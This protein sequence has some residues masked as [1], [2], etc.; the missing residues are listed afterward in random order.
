VINT[1]TV[2]DTELLSAGRDLKWVA[3]LGSGLD[4]IDLVQAEQ[5]GIHVIS[6][7]K[8]NA[9]AVAEHV[10]GMLLGLLRH[11]VIS[12]REVRR[13]E[14][15]R[16]KNRGRELQGMT[17]GI[18][19]FGNTG[20]AFAGKLAGWQLQVLAYDK[21]KSDYANDYPHV[22]ET[23]LEEVLT[24][25][26]VLSLHVPLTAETGYMVNG[27][28]LAKCKPGAILVNSSRG[29]I[30]D[31]AALVLALRTGHLA[32]ACLDVQENERP[33]T[34]TPDERTLYDILFA[35]SNVVLTP[36]VAGWTFAS[37]RRIAEAILRAL[38]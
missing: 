21:Y 27:A 13:G 10:V 24:H 20:S 22:R 35:M 5:R 29:K 37:K 14:W 28:F 9:N 8:A 19:G 16:E 26:D 31:T 33:D 30:V 1:R 3:R 7:P 18:I 2:A 36:H 23:T 4:I 34:F 12:D 15:L 32:G 11:I 25:S 6:T 38:E 17:V